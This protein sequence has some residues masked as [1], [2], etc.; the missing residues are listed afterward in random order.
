M[1][2]AWRKDT[3]SSALATRDASV[4]T[5][6]QGHTAAQVSDCRECHSLSPEVLGIRGNGCVRCEQVGYL[7]SLVVEQREEVDRLR[8]I[9]EL[10]NETE[11]WTETLIRTGKFIPLIH[12]SM[13]GVS[14]QI[15]G[16]FTMS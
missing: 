12:G 8:N 10:E 9:R 4:Q 16:S 7:F 5:D 13:I 2:S 14:I 6:L 11:M 3:S 1:V 15:L